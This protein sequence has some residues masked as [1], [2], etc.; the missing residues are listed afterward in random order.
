MITNILRSNLPTNVTEKM[1]REDQVK[2]E[3]AMVR[4]STTVGLPAPLFRY[5]VSEYLAE[6]FV[7]DEDPVEIP[8]D[9]EAGRKAAA[10]GLLQLEINAILTKQLEE[11]LLWVSRQPGAPREFNIARSDLARKR[12]ALKLL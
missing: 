1:I 11:V 6:D 4:H 12:I 2:Y 8:P 5:P 7:V 10:K 9:E 3:E